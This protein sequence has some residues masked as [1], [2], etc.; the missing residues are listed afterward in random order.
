LAEHAAGQRLAQKWANL[1]VERLLSVD[2]RVR[3]LSCEP[4]LSGIDLSP[5]LTLKQIDWV[6][7]GGES[8]GQARPTHPNWIRSLRD[9]QMIHASDHPESLKLMVRAYRHAVDPEEPPEQ[10][11]I[12]LE[13]L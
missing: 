10:L 11:K 7:A 2:A 6:I 9:H 1:R 3:F 8:G 13:G 5:W 12:E 4:L